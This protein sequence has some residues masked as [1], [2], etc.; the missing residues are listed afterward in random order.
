MTTGPG[1]PTEQVSYSLWHFGAA[2]AQQDWCPMT[3]L[4]GDECSCRDLVFFTWNI[5][6]LEERSDAK[7]GLAATVSG[8]QPSHWQ[9]TADTD[10]ETDGPIAVWFTFERPVAWGKGSLLLRDNHC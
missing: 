7:F 6:T 8:E 4:F 10:E 1:S 5:T 3:A 2:I 9:I